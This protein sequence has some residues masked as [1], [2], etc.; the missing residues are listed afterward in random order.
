MI[1][2]IQMVKHVEPANE[3]SILDVLQKII[4]QSTRI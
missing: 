4:S 3:T 2:K 1:K